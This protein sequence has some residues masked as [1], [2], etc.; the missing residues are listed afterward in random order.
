M[1]LRG[2]FSTFFIVTPVKEAKRAL[3]A[4]EMSEAE[5]IAFQT[6]QAMRRSG[7]LAADED[8]ITPPYNDMTGSSPW[9]ELTRWPVY[10]RGK[11]FSQ[12]AARA[13]LPNPIPWGLVVSSRSH[14]GLLLNYG[15]KVGA[16]DQIPFTFRE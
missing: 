16:T 1:F 2:E 5:F 3:E 8:E 4:S 11:S 13:A 12:L 6:D 14:L 10:F 15:R 9:L 7:S